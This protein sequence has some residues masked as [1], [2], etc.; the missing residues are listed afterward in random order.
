[1]KRGEKRQH[2][3]HSKRLRGH[4][5][6]ARISQRFLAARV[7]TQLKVLWRLYVPEPTDLPGGEG[8]MGEAE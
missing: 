2:N 3:D 7:A 1:M 6:G 8:T 4:Q 5:H